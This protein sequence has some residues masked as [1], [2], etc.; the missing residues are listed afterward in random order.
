MERSFRAHDFLLGRYNCQMF[1][2]THFCLP[3]GNP[4]IAA[5]Q[6]EAGS[7][8]QSIE[9]TFAVNPP[10]GVTVP[11]NGKVWVPI[12]PLVGSAF[13][14]IPKPVRGKINKAAIQ[15][16]ADLI[17]KRLNA[18]KD[19]LLASAPAGWL[20]KLFVGVLC[21]WPTRLM[22]RGKIVDKLTA[23]LSQDVQ[24]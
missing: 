6:S 23:A 12:I 14:P 16:I 13:N 7:F 22:V 20:C 8:A 10:S 19:P 17:L 11:P 2:K 5:G 18:I 21:G 3:F 4:I 1:L 9:S 24:E 15:T